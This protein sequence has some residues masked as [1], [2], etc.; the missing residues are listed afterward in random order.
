MKNHNK[1][2]K[3]NWRFLFFILP[4]ILF[5]GSLLILLNISKNFIAPKTFTTQK[6]RVLVSEILR[7]N[8]QLLIAKAS[9]LLN[10]PLL[11]PNI[12]MAQLHPRHFIHYSSKWKKNL[13]VSFLVLTT[14]NGRVL[15]PS[16]NSKTTNHVQTKS[17]HYN[18]AQAMH[19]LPTQGIYLIQNQFYDLLTTPVLNHYQRYGILIIGIPLGSIINQLQHITRQKILFNFNHQLW[20][21]SKQNIMV[22]IHNPLTLTKKSNVDSNSVLVFS[23][24]HH[25]Y[26][27]SN[28]V[29]AS[30]N[31]NKKIKIIFLKK[32]F[33]NSHFLLN[34]L[35]IAILIL[36]F[37]L[38]LFSLILGMNVEKKYSSQFQKLNNAFQE[39]SHGN[40]D[41]SISVPFQKENSETFE[42]FNQMLGNLKQ[43][44]RI[45][46]ILGK[47]ISADVAAKLL[48][49]QDFF[50]L[51]G[52]K[53]E[54]CFM[55]ID[56]RGFSDN[57][58]N[59]NP[60]QF[61]KEVN[62][63][64]EQMIEIIFNYEGT[65]DKFVGFSICSI[66]GAPNTLLNKETTAINAAIAIQKNVIDYN[67][68]R[69]KKNLQPITLGIG[70]SNNWAITGNLGSKTRRDY[71][72]ISLET[73]VTEFLSHHAENGE[74]LISERLFE[75]IA[76]A[77]QCSPRQPLWYPPISQFIKVYHFDRILKSDD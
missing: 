74:I 63:F 71:T 2:L 65:V 50:S 75:K 3:F 41:F 19:G 8:D 17:N 58:E 67:I 31:P 26:L 28:L 1:H 14:T 20:R 47:N 18:I 66:W 55:F 33:L 56:T 21:T 45:Q 62:E 15:F 32:Y 76:Q 60:I 4:I 64:L 57:I 38:G 35:Q 39:V 5:A 59:K 23:N 30:L 9:I 61:L 73:Q 27:A 34:Q 10:N 49:S 43:K 69:L 12:R 53:R 48:N 24:N 40:F 7:Q 72:A 68:T 13:H 16:T 44:N 70:L 54:C 42:S 37:F 36:M 46:E 25:K 77:T 6:D 52:E 29:F 51:Q 22:K 11:I